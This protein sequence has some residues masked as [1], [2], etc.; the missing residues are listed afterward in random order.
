SRSIAPTQAF[1][2]GS[3]SGSASFFRPPERRLPAPKFRGQLR[4]P[5]ALHRAGGIRTLKLHH[6]TSAHFATLALTGALA[7]SL[8]C[9]A[10]DRPLDSDQVT[11]TARGSL[12]DHVEGVA[13]AIELP[14][15]APFWKDLDRSIG[16][17]PGDCGTCA[18]PV[19]VDPMSAS[20]LA[21][22]IVDRL[23]TS[24]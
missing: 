21:T 8:G 16:I 14:V 3:T 18:D 7:L 9:S 15:R 24:D 1:E 4:G 17:G 11:Q 5:D 22:D 6:P 13:R 12:H 2:R 23:L 19:I 10:G 20:D